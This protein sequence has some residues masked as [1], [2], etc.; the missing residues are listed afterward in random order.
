[1]NCQKCKNEI[2]E[3]NLRREGLSDAAE[4]HLSACADCHVFGEERLALSR[5]VGGLEKVSAPADFDFRM[6][7]RMAAEASA[8]RATR[9]G[10]FNF[11]PAALSWPLAACFALV[12]SATFYF[13]QQPSPA[14][15]TTT[16][17]SRTVAVMETPAPQA[18]LDETISQNA[19]ALSGETRQS[20]DTPS[21]KNALAARRR[22]LPV[23]AVGRTTVDAAQVRA[24]VEESN[25]AS[26][27]S[28]PVM[29]AA[30]NTAT[31]GERVLIPLQV[32]AQERPLKVLLQ[33]TGGNARTISVDSVSFGSRDVIGRPATISKASLSTNQGVW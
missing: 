7:A 4:A 29:H 16:E 21:L 2:E 22:M 14:M 8:G 13:Q 10:W 12:I 19:P 28:V 11:S 5:L 15:S 1:M 24:A 23:R 9:S 32:S 6:R 30:N 18:S 25:S 27:P 3:R 17:Q 20:F 31:T 33:E 26:L